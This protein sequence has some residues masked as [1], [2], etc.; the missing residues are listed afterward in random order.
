[1]L[2]KLYNII[3]SIIPD[4]GKHNNIQY[5]EN[6]ISLE[7]LNTLNRIEQTAISKLENPGYW[8][9]VGNIEAAAYGLCLL[10]IKTM[11]KVIDNE[12]QKNIQNSYMSAAKKIFIKYFDDYDEDGYGMSTFNYFFDNSREYSAVPFYSG[13]PYTQTYWQNA[14]SASKNYI[15]NSAQYYKPTW[16]AAYINRLINSVTHSKYSD[17]LYDQEIRCKEITKD[18]TAILT[19]STVNSFTDAFK[20]CWSEN[21]HLHT[22]NYEE[23]IFLKYN[24][25]LH[26]IISLLDILN[27]SGLSLHPIRLEALS[28][29]QSV[30][31]SNKIVICKLPSI[32]NLA[33]HAA[34][35]EMMFR[36]AELNRQFCMEDIRNDNEKYVIYAMSAMH[37]GHYFN[38]S[39]I[40]SD[41]Q[42]SIIKGTLKDD[43]ISHICLANSKLLRKEL[44]NRYK[45]LISISLD[46]RTEQFPQITDT[47]WFVLKLQFIEMIVKAMTENTIKDG[48]LNIEDVIS[49]LHSIHDNVIS[50]I[51]KDGFFISDN[52][53]DSLNKIYLDK[54][55]GLTV[56]ALLEINRFKKSNLDKTLIELVLKLQTIN[57]YIETG[58][59]SET[60]EYTQ[61]ITNRCFDRT[62]IFIKY[63]DYFHAASSLSHLHYLA[64][65]DEREMQKLLDFNETLHSLK[66]GEEFEDEFD[67]A[68]KYN[69]IRQSRELGRPDLRI[70]KY[71]R[72]N[73]SL[74]NET[75]DFDSIGLAE[76]IDRQIYDFRGYVTGDSEEIQRAQHLQ[77]E[78]INITANIGNDDIINDPDKMRE[79]FCLSKSVRLSQT[80]FD[81]TDIDDKSVCIIP[82]GEIHRVPFDVIYYF[83]TKSLK[84]K[85]PESSVIYSI[86]QLVHPE[87]VQNL[88]TPIVVFNPDYSHSELQ[89]LDELEHSDKE[90]ESISKYFKINPYSGQNANRANFLS[91]KQPLFF[92][93]ATHMGLQDS[94]QLLNDEQ[95]IN[96]GT[97]SQFRINKY[98]AER[99]R[100]LALASVKK[101]SNSGSASSAIQGLITG[102]DFSKINLK[103]TK[104]VVLAGCRSALN[105][106]NDQNQITGFV[107]DAFTAGCESVVGALWDIE[108]ETYFVFMDCLYKEL[109]TGKT[110]GQA[111]RIAQQLIIQKY[112]DVY[113][114]GGF[115]LYGNINMRLNESN[116]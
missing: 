14:V 15:E 23:M 18:I 55:I 70:I 69:E 7:N 50:K 62:I 112:D 96:I 108:D 47:G 38:K 98:N 34:E 85:W 53:Q 105:T 104:M 93:I 91:V 11:P 21:N 27:L 46:N 71:A 88:N 97:S 114:W 20:S 75:I 4:T 42:N 6:D 32:D 13:N 95:M 29:L 5:F 76:H 43:T 8:G 66:D 73:L 9:E 107:H 83:Y 102:V 25:I 103:G 16:D 86:K 74:K 82:H 22:E 64:S 110:I 2:N 41:E 31:N 51:N 39:N 28:I 100:Y 80:L 40:L 35:S 63:L 33:S 111:F 17:I 84:C 19:G 109:G 68:E 94:T 36:F 87:P 78:Y 90:A 116:A 60:I 30:L 92:H 65:Y 3:K 54:L 106:V 77:P 44:Y 101:S 24:L 52:D 67:F 45:D 89:H 72:F 1:M 99:S 57:N 59:L 26:F 81:N 49:D 12:I 115:A 113:H 56:S 61:L 48:D 10:A 79:F 58:T 37:N